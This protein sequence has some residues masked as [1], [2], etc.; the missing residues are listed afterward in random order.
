MISVDVED[1]WEERLLNR[2]KEEGNQLFVLLYLLNEALHSP[3]PV[4]VKA[5]AC[6]MWRD[7]L[8]KIMDLISVAALDCLLAEV[9]PKTVFHELVEVAQNGF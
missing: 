5:D 6:Q 9:V 3:R 7:C 1:D 2:R 8:K 4:I